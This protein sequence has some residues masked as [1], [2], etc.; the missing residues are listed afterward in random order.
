MNE[1]ALTLG[2]AVDHIVDCTI[3]SVGSAQSEAVTAQRTANE[4][5]QNGESVHTNLTL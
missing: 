2:R 5:Q 4:T 1:T 3:A